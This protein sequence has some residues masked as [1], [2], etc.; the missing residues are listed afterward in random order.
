MAEHETAAT[1][2]LHELELKVEY[3]R[4][5]FDLTYAEAI[6]CLELIKQR[7]VMETFDGDFVEEGE[8]GEDHLG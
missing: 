7:L 2:F 1:C 8:D 4:V 5:E 3:F 6:G